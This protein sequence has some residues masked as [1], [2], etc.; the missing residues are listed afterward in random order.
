MIGQR[1]KQLRN[2]HNLTL[3]KLASYLDTTSITL[4]RYENNQRQPDNETLKKIADYFEVTTDFLLERTNIPNYK[5]IMSGTI[6][7]PVYW[8]YG[9]ENQNVPAETLEVVA[10]AYDFVLDPDKLIAFRIREYNYIPYFLAGDILIIE[11]TE[12]INTYSQFYLA[13]FGTTNIILEL[14]SDFQ[15]GTVFTR[16][17][18]EQ[19]V[20]LTNAIILGRV[21]NLLRGL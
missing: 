11:L 13:L 5:K 15:K 12:E 2:K 18:L 4:S 6:E 10:S 21:I 14:I 1:L 17:T 16:I 8:S 19:R 3:S 20:A 9:V 7:I